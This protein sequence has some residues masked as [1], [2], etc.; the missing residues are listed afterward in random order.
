[1][2]E[3]FEHNHNHLVF[4]YSPRVLL[5]FF[6]PSVKTCWV[7]GF[8]PV[9]SVWSLGSDLLGLW[10]EARDRPPL[11]NTTGEQDGGEDPA[12]CPSCPV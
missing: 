1:M 12:P 5:T 9:G 4:S 3:H 6:S 2:N 10:T 11:E 7:F 8:R